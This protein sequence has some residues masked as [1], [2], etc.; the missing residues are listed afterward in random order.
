MSMDRRDFLKLGAAAT[1]TL[2][3]EPAWA[4]TAKAEILWLGQ[5]ATRITTLTGKVIVIDPFLT[6]N[7]KTPPEWKNLDKLG[8]VDVILVTHGHGDHTGDI[9]ELAERTG[10]KV[11]GPAGLIAT[12]IELGWVNAEQGVRFGKGGTVTPLGP[13]IKIT[14]VRAEHSSEVTVVDPDTK[15]S[16][17]YPGGEPAGFVVELENGFKLYHMGDTGL[18]GDMRFIAEYYKPDLVLM[19]IGGHFVMDPR[20]AAYATR[21]MLKP[22]YVVPI[23]YGTFP[24]LKGTPQEYQQ[25]LGQTTTQVFPLSPGDVVRF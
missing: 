2:A 10:A 3:T 13:A 18:F 6:K 12:M 22:R 19:P 20:D 21:Q 7:P 4:Q 16:T 17:T 1:F 5:A 11:F 8:K 9:K 24:V 14:Q 23:H 15:K 25:F